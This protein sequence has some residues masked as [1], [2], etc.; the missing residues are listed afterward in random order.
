MKQNFQLTEVLNTVWNNKIKIVI[1]TFIAAVIGAV[2]TFILPKLYES[3]T[4]FVVKAP[5]Y[6]SRASTFVTD[7]NNEIPFEIFAN[8]KEIDIVEG[9]VHSTFFKE[10]IANKINANLDGFGRKQSISPKEVD[11]SYKFKRNA[12]RVQRISITSREPSFSHK[13]SN[14]IIDE[15]NQEFNKYF[16]SNFQQKKLMLEQELPLLKQ[17]I[18]SLDQEIEHIRTQYGLNHELAPVRGNALVN[19]SHSMVKQGTEELYN[20]IQLKDE[21]LQNAI[22]TER[23]ILQYSFMASEEN[24]DML[25]IVSDAYEP[26]HNVFP[27][28]KW[29]II[30]GGLLGFFVSVLGII[31]VQISKK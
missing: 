27:Q 8:E 1:F 28:L 25:Y 6:N 15:L 31:I 5:L 24:L 12:Q 3:N 10:K 11:K 7:Y 18:A 2:L 23:S 17:Q 16:L 13:L 19:T 9:I 29:M 21:L 26:S 30:I 4:Y 22:L 20:L 14:L